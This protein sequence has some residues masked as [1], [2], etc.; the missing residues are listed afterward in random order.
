MTNAPAKQ[1]IK[2]IQIIP[3]ATATFLLTIFFGF[4]SLTLAS[5]IFSCLHHSQFLVVSNICLARQIHTLNRIPKEQ[6]TGSVCIIL[7]VFPNYHH[8]RV[9]RNNTF[10]DNK[11][12]QSQLMHQKPK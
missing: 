9:L 1:A 7:K 3:S 10:V 2:T 4:A 6:T 8:K 11:T 5:L 12:C